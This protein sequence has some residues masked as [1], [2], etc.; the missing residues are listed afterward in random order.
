MFYLVGAL[1]QSRGLDMTTI[2]PRALD[3]DAIRLIARTTETS[4]RREE[5]ETRALFA[6]ILARA[7]RLYRRAPAD[8]QERK[9]T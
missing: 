8:S 4:E 9:T 6:P 7:L 3:F 5:E 1:A 2:L